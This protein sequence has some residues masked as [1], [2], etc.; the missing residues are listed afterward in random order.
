M[1]AF[2][3][4]ETLLFQPGSIP[5]ILVIIANVQD[6]AIFG[7]N[8]N[9]ADTVL[10]WYNVN[11][12]STANRTF[13]FNIGSTSIGLNRL[14]GPD[15]LALQDRWQHLVAV[16]SGKVERFIITVYWLQIP[17]VQTILLQLR[18]IMF[19]L[20]LGQGSGN[21]DF[22][23]SLDE[24]RFYNRSFTDDDVTILYG[25]GNGDLGLDPNYY[26]GC[27]QCISKHNWKGRIF[28]VWGSTVSYRTR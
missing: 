19:G 7:T 11:G 18:E 27:C 17:S 5:Q 23:G 4:M 12:V 1:P 3:K 2:I 9:T 13:T 15:G 24:V 22:E 25:H 21:M 28:E 10:V 20:V 26:F 6:A 8:G 16:M 14:D